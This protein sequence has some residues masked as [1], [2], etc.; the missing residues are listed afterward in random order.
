MGLGLHG[1]GLA[2]ALFFARRGA[3][4]TV[5]DLRSE[6][7]LLASI[8]KLAA[9][10]VRYV[11]GRH[12]TSDFTAADLVVKNPGVRL[13]SPY[14]AAA[15]LAGVRIETDVSI[16]ANLCD[17]PILAVT[18]SKGKSTTASAM[19]WGVRD[20]YPGARLGGNITVSPLTFLEELAPADPV[21]LELSSWQLADLAGCPRFKPRVSLITNI[22]PDHLNRYRDMDEYVADKKLIYAC[23]DGTDVSIFNLDDPRTEEF[24]AEARGR[25]LFFSSRPLPEDAEGGWL[26]DEAARLRLDGRLTTILD[27]PLSLPGEHNRRNLLA[28][29]VALSAWG[30]APG[31]LTERL[32]LFPGIEHRLELV[33]EKNGIRYYN[34]SAATIPHAMRE[35][36]RALSGLK[37][38]G[39]SSGLVLI[40]GGADKNIDFAPLADVARAPRAIVLLDGSATAKIAALLD[41][42]GVPYRGPFPRLEPAVNEAAAAARP[43]DAVLFSPGCASFGLFQ[44]EFDRGRQFKEIVLR[45]GAD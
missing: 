19:H 3:A 11:L 8:G 17:N 14:L 1:G 4:V 34:D 43:G 45:P 32:A 26:E 36:V 37:A 15:R 9:H 13:D 27:R 30:M 38:D 20:K 23:Q 12:E 2:S 6:G 7:D 21:V 18:G 5:T 28:A 22:L 16:F 25:K 29:A 42:L 35:A 31:S 24:R 41:S 40:T 10:P 33:V 39:T 44:N